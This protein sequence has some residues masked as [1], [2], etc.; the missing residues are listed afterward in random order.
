MVDRALK[1]ASSTIRG[2]MIDPATSR[3]L[4]AVY[5]NVKENNSV[6]MAPVLKLSFTHAAINHIASLGKQIMTNLVANDDSMQQV[7][8][9]PTPIVPDRRVLDRNLHLQYFNRFQEVRWLCEHP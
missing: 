2:G 7:Y 9:F 6:D 5:D 1:E 4:Q 3:Q 8:T